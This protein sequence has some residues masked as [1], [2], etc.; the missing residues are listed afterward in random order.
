MGLKYQRTPAPSHLLPYLLSHTIS[1]SLAVPHL[2][3][4]PLILPI[5]F[6]FKKITY[7]PFHSVSLLSFLFYYF[8]V[9]C[10]LIHVRLYNLMNGFTSISCI[11]MIL[12][13]YHASFDTKILKVRYSS[14]A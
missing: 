7:S 11:T 5:R 9:I 6:F 2:L 8:P 13:E 3:P 12:V 14:T 10:S 1:P 4:L